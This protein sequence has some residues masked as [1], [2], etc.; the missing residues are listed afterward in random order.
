MERFLKVVGWIPR[1]GKCSRP[2]DDIR[3]LA[4]LRWTQLTQE[5]KNSPGGTNIHFC[6]T[7]LIISRAFTNRFHDVVSVTLNVTVKVAYAIPKQS[8]IRNKYSS[9]YLQLSYYFLRAWYDRPSSS[10]GG[11][12]SAACLHTGLAVL[13]HR[14]LKGRQK[15]HVF[16][17]TIHLSCSRSNQY[18]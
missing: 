1:N 9:V 14:F 18:L 12:T 16:S 17:S 2:A 13:L 4:W 7:T 6:T 3:K 5:L 8:F 10:A 11:G 15:A